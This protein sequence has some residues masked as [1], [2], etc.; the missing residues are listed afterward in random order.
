LPAAGGGSVPSSTNT[1]RLWRFGVFEVDAQT[2]ELRRAGVS[3]KI[4]DQ[5]FRILLFLVEHAGEIVTREQLRNVLWSS[6]VFVDFDH[7]LYSAMMK[8]REVLGDTADKPLYI[9]TLPKKGYRFIAPITDSAS[10][11][12]SAPSA[13]GAIAAVPDTTAEQPDASASIS[14]TAAVNIRPHRR[15]WPWI[16]FAG[17]MVATGIALAS[18]TWFSKPPTLV[19]TSIERITHDGLPKTWL[20]TDGA[21]IYFSE[22]VKE[23]FPLVQV[24]TGGGEV[25]IIATPFERNIACDV[26]PD[27]SSLLVSEWHWNNEPSP[28]WIVPIPGGA[29]R[30]VGNLL[31]DFATWSPD[32]SHAP[33]TCSPPSAVEGADS[34]R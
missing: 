26:A 21:R 4:R 14:A 24:S 12:D 19:V 32:G 2:A 5:P 33:S 7:S 22:E 23:H 8:L 10:L 28:L 30:R 16:V 13:S 3:V 31:A 29:L 20:V 9:E 27:K 1:S 18:I 11:R 15:R 34:L 6:D 25:S 17:T